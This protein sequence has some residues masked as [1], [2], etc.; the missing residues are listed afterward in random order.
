[1]RSAYRPQH[2]RLAIGPSGATK[3][4]SYS[5]AAGD[6]PSARSA[7]CPGVGDRTCAAG[8]CRIS[9]Q[10][11]A[12]LP[13][14]CRTAVERFLFFLSPLRYTLTPNYSSL[15]HGSASSRRSATATR[16]TPGL[17]DLVRRLDHL[18]CAFST[19]PNAR[20]REQGDPRRRHRSVHVP[21]W[22]TP[23]CGGRRASPGLALQS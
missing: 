8:A 14:S 4:S 5:G 19:P 11:S 2:T 22:Y 20:P 13:A 16:P 7:A 9:N 6:T 23:P 12:V 21:S 17:P 15:E 18:A 1:M 3:S 10:F